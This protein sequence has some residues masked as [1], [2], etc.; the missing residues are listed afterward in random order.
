MESVY[1]T[2]CIRH[3]NFIKRELWGRNSALQIC[4]ELRPVNKCLF[5]MTWSLTATAYVTRVLF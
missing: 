5:S 1:L 4:K 2:L 3:A